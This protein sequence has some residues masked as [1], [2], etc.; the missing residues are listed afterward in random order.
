MANLIFTLFGLG[1]APD[2][3]QGVVAQSSATLADDRLYADQIDL[4]GRKILRIG[5]VPLCW[6]AQPKLFGFN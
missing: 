1:V 5:N 2:G 6:T 3:G 4:A